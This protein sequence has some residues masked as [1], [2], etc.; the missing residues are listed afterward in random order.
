MRVQS[1]FLRNK[2][3]NVSAIMRA[4]IQR[5]SSAKVVVDGVTVGSIG[6]G[7]LVLLGVGTDDVEKD[8]GMHLQILLRK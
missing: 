7:L 6:K 3:Y 2:V 8:G 5:V 1:F 4:L